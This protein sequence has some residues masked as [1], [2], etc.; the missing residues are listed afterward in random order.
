MIM[1]W[2]GISKEKIQPE[3]ST[4]ALSVALTLTSQFTMQLG[5]DGLLRTSK[6]DCIPKDIVFWAAIYEL[7]SV[8][9]LLMQHGVSVESEYSQ[10]V[11][12]WLESKVM[13][14]YHFNDP[15]M[16]TLHKAARCGHGAVALLLL[17]HGAD[18]NAPGPENGGTP[19]H[20]AAAG[21]HGHVVQLLLENGA[22]ADALA[23]PSNSGT[24]HHAATGG[25]R[26]AMELILRNLK[27]VGIDQADKHSQTALHLAAAAGHKDLVQLLLDKGALVGRKASRNDGE[28]IHF[29]AAQG[30]VDVV[31][32][33]LARGASVHAI[34][35]LGRT[36]LFSAAR[37]GHESVVRLL[38]ENGADANQK[39]TTRRIR[40]V[41]QYGATPLHHAVAGWHTG[42]VLIL[43][44]HGADVNTRDDDGGTPLDNVLEQVGHGPRSL[45]ANKRA[46]EMVDLLM[47]NGATRKPKTMVF[48]G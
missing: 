36:P 10:L 5:E 25:N 46:R 19:L 26:Q 45:E 1:S 38:L 39:A 31:R 43:I 13:L 32:L 40:G 44:Q 27:A 24:L 47:R 33:L 22:N 35:G 29:A 21:G 18:V 17:E 28:P 14:D 7:E 23:R 30:H 37:P 15:E 2:L 9:R 11:H 48:R 8:F 20:Q 12:H 4:K 42:V 3:N 6:V 34:D 16:T 41:M